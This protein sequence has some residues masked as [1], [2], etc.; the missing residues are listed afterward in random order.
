MSIFVFWVALAAGGWTEIENKQGVTVERRN[1]DGSPFPELRLQARSRFSPEQLAA[2]V[3]AKRNGKYERMKKLS[4]KI[5]ETPTERVFYEQIATPVIS[6]RD[7]T[8]RLRLLADRATNV[9][10]VI[11]Q[12]DN[13]AGPPPDPHL[14]R[15]EKMSGTWSF[16]PDEGGGTHVTYICHSDPAGSLPAFIAK[17]AQLDAAKDVWGEVEAW[18]AAHPDAK[19]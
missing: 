3:W 15:I 11:Y 7:Y 14:V 5:S 9:F 1:L 19:L 6:D 10:Q 16:E 18:A 8:V 2:A 4:K 12:A 13:Q 17:G